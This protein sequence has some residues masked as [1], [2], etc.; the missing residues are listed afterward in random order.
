MNRRLVGLS[1]F[2]VCA[3]SKAGPQPEVTVSPSTRRVVTAGGSTITIGGANETIGISTE[4]SAAPDT[5]F[6][7]LLAVYGDLNV[8]TPDVSS[9]QRAVGNQRLQI[10]R[11]LGG[12]PLQT[13]LDC[14]GNPGQPNAET[15]DIVMTLMSLVTPGRAGGSTVTT[16]VQAVGSD[17]THGAGNQLR[18][19]STSELEGRIAKMVRAK[20]GQ[21]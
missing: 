17:P 1:V 11:R 4:I 8:A 13:Y 19:S 2:A 16:S 15:F 21:K 6:K 3:C 14:G 7:A 9:A 5:V 20:L 18:C 10:R 12:V